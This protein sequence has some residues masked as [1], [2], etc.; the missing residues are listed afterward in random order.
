MIGHTKWVLVLSVAVFVF[1][2]ALEVGRWLDRID[3]PSQRI[4]GATLAACAVFLV[5]WTELHHLWYGNFQII[6]TA[7]YERYGDAVASAQVP[8]RDFDLE[9]PPGSIAAFAAPELTAQRGEFGTYGHAF[10]KWAG[11]WGV[12]MVVLVGVALLA[13][14]LPFVEAAG[15]L[16]LVAVSPL[17]LGNV[18]LSRFDLLPAALA[19]GAVA[20]LLHRRDRLAAVVLAAA[21]CVKLYPAV[22]VP[23]AVAWIWRRRGRDD[24]L[25]WLG[26]VAAICA[27]VF[28]PFA[29]LSPGGLAHSFGTQLGRP[30]QLESLGS[31]L[32]IAAHHVANVHLVMASS[33]GSQNLENGAAN[34]LGIVSSVL[35][36]A[37]IAWICFAFARGPATRDRL[38]VACAGAI[39]AFVAF[40][41]VFSLQYMVW[42][43][44]AVALVRAAWPRLLLIAGLVL[45]QLWFPRHYWSLAL[46]FRARESW[47]LLA[48]DL[49]VVALVVVLGRELL[50]D[51]R[52]RED[53]PVR[54]PVEPVRGQVELGSS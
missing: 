49:V 51:E 15:G 11:A 9:Y 41:K 32:L 25:R 10:E 33:H 53:S 52:L 54:E 30:L 24:A 34:A 38:V 16:A 21:I 39:A 13:L 18:V 48:R 37:A 47:L 19:T 31:A 50:Q 27:A 23:I 20:A 26:L 1:V 12:A 7:I 35:Q 45:T 22:L 14:R 3:A 44:P 40:G 46:E 43:V 42:L 17:L 2:V 6:D 28:I 36:V 4:A 5:S 8:Y 29:I